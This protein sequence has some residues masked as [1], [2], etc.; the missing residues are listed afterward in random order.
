MNAMQRQMIHSG[1]LIIQQGDPGNKFYVLEEGGSEVLVD[2]KVVG[3]IQPG[4]AFGELAL[5]YNCPRAA[6]IRAKSMCTVWTLGGS[7]FGG[8][9]PRR[10]LPQSRA[11]CLF[12]K[13]AS[14]E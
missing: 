6:T 8:Y 3:N 7:H 12:E 14:A 9:W 1:D 13:S 10:R 11:L 2:G 5:M 4:G